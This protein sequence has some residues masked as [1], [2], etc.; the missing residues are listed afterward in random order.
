VEIAA[1]NEIPHAGMSRLKSF[2]NRK[3]NVGKK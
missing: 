1:N 3:I 2:T